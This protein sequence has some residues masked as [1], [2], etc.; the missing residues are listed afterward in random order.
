MLA[1]IYIGYDASTT[2]KKL[3]REEYKDLRESVEQLGLEEWAEDKPEPPYWYKNSDTI[4][5]DLMEDGMMLTRYGIPF[6]VKRFKG[7]YHVNKTLKDGHQGPINYNL[8]VAIPSIGTLL[9]DEVC[10]LD[11]SCTDILQDHLNDGW[12]ILAVCPPNAQRRPDYILG[13]QRPAG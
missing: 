8:Q 13:R 10:H 9:I 2:I 7:A 1:A 11:D 3:S 12:R 6:Q 5:I 4:V